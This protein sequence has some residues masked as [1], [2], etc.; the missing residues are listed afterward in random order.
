MHPPG[1]LGSSSFGTSAG[2]SVS[3]SSR[4]RGLL[5][6]FPLL[7]RQRGGGGAA[8]TGGI[9][10][11][12]EGDQSPLS[13]LSLA[14]TS[15]SWA[16][17]TNGVLPGRRVWRRRSMRGR[18][19]SHRAGT[20]LTGRCLRRRQQPRQVRRG[21]HLGQGLGGDWAETRARAS[22]VGLVLLASSCSLVSLT[23]AGARRRRRRP[24]PPERPCDHRPLETKWE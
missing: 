19:R 4:E 17:C 14:E 10:H 2:D 16:S 13:V 23:P 18:I 5:Q 21:L 8:P 24:R 3:G 22:D 15:G 6:M 20:V 1:F 7:S 12:M 11:L 9:E